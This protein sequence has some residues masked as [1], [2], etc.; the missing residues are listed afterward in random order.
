M[1]ALLAL[2]AFGWY[3]IVN[4]PSEPEI[5]GQT[6]HVPDA[7]VAPSNSNSVPNTEMLPQPR[8]I[9]QPPN[10]NFYQNSKQNLKGDLLINFVGFTMYYP[11]DWKVNGPGRFDAKCTR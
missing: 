3:Y 2:L 1:F 6:G 9:P 5:Q 4:H 10:T 8:N 7:N 11:K